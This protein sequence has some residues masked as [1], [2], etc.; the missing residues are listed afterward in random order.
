MSL[1]ETVREKI[2]RILR[3]SKTPLSAAEIAAELGLNPIGGEKIVYEHLK[4]IAKSVWRSSRGR[5]SLFMIP[6]RCMKCGYVFKDLREPRK[7]SKCPRCKSQWI[8]P[9]RFKIM[10]YK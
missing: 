6:P 9:P 4:H 3:E 1:D 2:I 8:E 7:P 5:E 10:E